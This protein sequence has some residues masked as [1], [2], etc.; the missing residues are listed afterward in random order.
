M[1]AR[2]SQNSQKRDSAQP[3]GSYSGASFN[4]VFSGSTNIFSAAVELGMVVAP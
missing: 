1:N 3:S 2:E 4:Q